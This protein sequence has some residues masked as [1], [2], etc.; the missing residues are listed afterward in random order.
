MRL[1][2]IYIVSISYVNHA[3]AS[4]PDSIVDKE[5]YVRVWSKLSLYKIRTHVLLVFLTL[6]YSNKL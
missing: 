5:F 1:F 2:G 4:L 3:C 6:C